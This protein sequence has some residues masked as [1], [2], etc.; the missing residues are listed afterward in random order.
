M[1]KI[2]IWKIWKLLQMIKAK[3]LRK[4]LN[5]LRLRTSYLSVYRK[6]W[7][8]ENKD[9]LNNSARLHYLKKLN[10]LGEEY[11]TKLNT[12]NRETRKSKKEKI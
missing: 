7:I 6:K 5:T 4:I 3:K 11:R 10:D 2:K 9:K 1:M 12:K 8:K